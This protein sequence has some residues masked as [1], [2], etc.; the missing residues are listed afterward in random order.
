MRI[1]RRARESSSPRI[2]GLLRLLALA[3]ILF[4][5]PFTGA[6][7][8]ANIRMVVV[9]YPDNNDGSPGNFLVDQS[10][11]AAVAAGSSDRVEIHNEYL[12]VSPVRTDGFKQLQTEFLRQKYVGRKVDLVIAGLSSGLDFILAHRERI[13]PGVPIVFC[14][15]DEREVRA[16]KLPPDVIG[17]PLKMDLLATLDLALQLHPNTERVFVI[18]GMAKF[19]AD[20]EAEARQAFRA[21]DKLEFVY[22]T[23]LRLEDLLE[24]I[25]HL[26]ERSIIYYLHVVQDGTGRVLVPAEV[27]ALLAAKANAPIYGHV[28]SYVGRGLVGGRV[29]RWETEGTNAAK[30]GLRILAG[31]KPERIGVQKTSANTYLFDWRQLQRWGIREESLPPGS[32]L[33]HR[34]PSLWALYRWHISGVISLCVIETLLI[35]GLL[36]QRANRRRAEDRFLRAVEAAPNGMLL[37]GPEGHIV[38]VN[39]HMERLFGYRKEE[40]LGQPVEMLV[41]ERFGKQHPAH[42][43]RFFAS[44]LIRPMGAGRDVFGCRKDGSEFP[45][46][47]GLSPIQTDAGLFVMASVI[48][49]SERKRTEKALQASE[50]RYRTL[51]EK[52]NDAIFLETEDDVIVAVNQ[53]A[54]DLLGYSR[55]ELLAMKVPDLQAPEVRGGLGTV[56]KGELAKHRDNPFEGLDFHRDGRSIPVEITDALIEENGKRLVLSI[57]RDITERKQA[58]EGLRESERELRLLTGRL[59]QAQETERSRIARELHDDLN[60]SLA[61]LSVELDHL[62]QKPPESAP[63]LKGWIHALSAQVKQL[64]SSVHD[65]SHELHPSK[66]EQLGLVAAIRGLC[67][68]LIQAH[69]LPIEFSHHEVTEA[70]P[71][72]VALCLYRIVQEALRNVIKHSGAHQASVVLHQNADALRLRIIDDGIGFDPTNVPCGGGLGLVSMRERLHL[73]RGQVAIDSQPSGGTR[74]DVRVPWCGNGQAEEAL[75]TQA[76]DIR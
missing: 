73:V 44:P 69:G 1:D 50:R 14:A 52:A 15:V 36:V 17:V 31:E 35:V 72:D 42:R 16:R 68:E 5:G 45:V 57:V 6:V 24:E 56:I 26:P 32:V 20:W 61:L 60:Q 54:C 70:I 13:F 2:F 65:L 18:A 67:N 12:D 4:F 48:D 7:A 75:P 47:I 30:L 38:L 59:L 55:E 43:D 28:D 51:F 71:Q 53:R 34:E 63:E 3:T 21:Y 8:A 25:S 58:E 64:S 9:L 41:P 22:L 33:R 11:R 76:A 37:V 10:I 19:D 29:F 74:I 27:L 66:L 40:L 39:A 49:L 23:K 46:E 62:G